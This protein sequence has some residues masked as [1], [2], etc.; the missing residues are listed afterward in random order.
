MTKPATDQ[1]PRA[2]GVSVNDDFL[3]VELADGEALEV[4]LEWFPGLL[5]VSAKALKNFEIVEEGQRIIWKDLGEDISLPGLLRG[6]AALGT[7][8]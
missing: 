3:T 1:G 2:T 4:P 5:E 6:I 7:V 8:D